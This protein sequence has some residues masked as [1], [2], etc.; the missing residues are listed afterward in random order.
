MSLIERLRRIAEANINELLDKAESPEKM[1]KQKIREL[2]NAIKDAK[3]AL[4]DFAVAFKKME[5]E[6]D[7]LKRLS[8]EWEQKAASAVKIDDEDMAKRALG[9]KVKAEERAQS[10]EPS[11]KDSKSRYE[12]LKGSLVTLQDQ[13][14]TAKLKLSELKSRKQTADAQKTFGATLDKAESSVLGDDEF[15]KMEESVLRAESEAEID[16]EIRGDRPLDEAS[17]EKK[18]RELQ[19]EAE[20]DAL[21]KKMKKK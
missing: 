18:S 19:V 9:E 5:K 11:V 3:S 10:L 6:Q 14:S 21:K 17:L 7:Q 20:L 4:A 16:H 12:E 8:A 13:L 15:S 2:E 1:L